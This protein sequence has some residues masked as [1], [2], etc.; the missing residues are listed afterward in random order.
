MVHVGVSG[1]W[2]LKV[3]IMVGNFFDNDY[4]GCFFEDLFDQSWDGKGNLEKWS[5]Q[6]AV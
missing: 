6:K 4:C 5:L 1:F 3:G 2:I